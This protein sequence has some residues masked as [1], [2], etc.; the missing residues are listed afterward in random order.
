MLSESH[1]EFSMNL[2][3]THM[4]PGP[5]PRDICPILLLD[6]ETIM[7]PRKSKVVVNKTIGYGYSNGGI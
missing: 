7:N 4:K 3:K 1:M 6:T 5:I 2:H